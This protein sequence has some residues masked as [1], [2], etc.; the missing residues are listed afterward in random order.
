MPPV[1]GSED[2]GVF[3]TAIDVPTVFWFWGGLEPDV[4][5]KALAENAIDQLPANHAPNFAPLIE[6][7]LSTGVEA[8]VIA[9]LAWLGS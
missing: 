6:P 8:L 5:F 1:N 7:T 4:V 2:V 9:A 3:G